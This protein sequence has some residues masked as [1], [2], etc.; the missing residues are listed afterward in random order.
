MLKDNQDA[1]GHG[2]LD[3]LNG[4][5]GQHEIAEVDNGY[6]E[7]SG[8]PQVYFTTYKEWP[9]IE[10]KAVR[11]ARGRILDI[12]CGAGRHSLYLQGKGLDVVGI[13]ISPLAVEVCKLRGLRDARVASIAQVSSKLGVIDTVLMFGNSCGL[14]GSFE[15]ARSL[16]RKLSNITSEK[17]R[18][19]A[20]T[21]DPYQTD[22]PEHLK[23]HDMNRQR[24]RM[25][26][27]IRLRIRYKTYATPWMDLLLVSKQE[28][29][30]I[31]DG[32]NW[33]IGKYI[34][35]EGSPRYVA[36]IDKKRV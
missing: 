14:S 23:Y 6:I 34:Q 13:D 7:T 19:I 4:I 15:R 3:Y 5:R 22:K 36:I 28:M 2:M 30:N 24:G 9:S 16:L 12:G 21:T 11:F 27:Q 35:I 31:L 17:G 26:G 32:T 29:E 20:Q 25:S 1:F 10:R 8:G 33:A 18:I